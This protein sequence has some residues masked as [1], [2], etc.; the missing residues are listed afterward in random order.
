LLIRIIVSNKVVST[1]PSKEKEY[2]VPKVR[3]SDLRR[4][5]QL[6]RFLRFAKR[7]KSAP[8]HGD[9]PYWGIPYQTGNIQSSQVWVTDKELLSYVKAVTQSEKLF[10]LS[11]N[12]ITWLVGYVASTM[13]LALGHLGGA[14]TFC[15]IAKKDR[16]RFRFFHRSHQGPPFRPD[17]I[18]VVARK[19]GVSPKKVLDLIK[20][21]ETQARLFLLF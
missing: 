13:G 15:E 8:D 5:K 6:L 10:D 4:N 9:L 16:W 7:R 12:T 19:L 21:D 20:K 17:S 1:N 11:P 14:F 18:A 2:E 3:L